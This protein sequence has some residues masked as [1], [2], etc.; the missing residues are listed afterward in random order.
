MAALEEFVVKDNLVVQGDP[1]GGPLG[2][3]Q[4]DTEPVV[5]LGILGGIVAE[6]RHDIVAVGG[7]QE[8]RFENDL[9]VKFLTFHDVHQIGDLVIRQGEHTGKLR[10]VIS[11]FGDVDGDDLIR[12]VLGLLDEHA[13]LFVP[14]FDTEPQVAAFPQMEIGSLGGNAICPL[15]GVATQT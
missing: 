15:V 2:F 6:G 1:H 7:G 3:G 5:K 14:N 11:A 4:V 12:R 8:G 10:Q 9:A 13:F